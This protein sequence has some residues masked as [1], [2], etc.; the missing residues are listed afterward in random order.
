M[1]Q[2]PPVVHEADMLAV[3]AYAQRKG[4]QDKK[5]RGGPRAAK[6]AGAGQPPLPPPQG[7]AAVERYP[8]VRGLRS[9][10]ETRMYLDRDK[11]SALE[12]GRL[13]CMELLGRARPAP[14]CRA[15]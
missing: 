1:G 8:E 13:R 11:S 5:R 14:F 7:A 6:V 2:R 9:V 3:A 15:R 10:P 12:I 4:A